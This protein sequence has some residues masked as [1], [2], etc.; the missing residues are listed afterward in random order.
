[1]F[2]TIVHKITQAPVAIIIVLLSAYRYLLSPFLGQNCRFYPSCSHYAKLAV[3]RHG[4][5][6]GLI[7]IARRIGKCHPMNPGGVDPV[8][9][10]QK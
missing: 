4:A 3:E 6:R 1:M 10:K 7:L 9:E 5:S 2:R 8:P